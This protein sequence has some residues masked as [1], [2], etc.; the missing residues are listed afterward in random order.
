[1]P[2]HNTRENQNSGAKGRSADNTANGAVFPK[3]VQT[4]NLT[5]LYDLIEQCGERFSYLSYEDGDWVAVADRGEWRVDLQTYCEAGCCGEY[6]GKDPI[7]AVTLLLDK[8]KE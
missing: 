2:T 4:L 1:M 8:I 3:E 5:E 7:S 6:Y